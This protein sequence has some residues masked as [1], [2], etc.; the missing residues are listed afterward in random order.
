MKD[1][2]MNTPEQIES[3]EMNSLTS[4]SKTTG[5]TGDVT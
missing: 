1:I 2:A 3:A 5:H 4:T